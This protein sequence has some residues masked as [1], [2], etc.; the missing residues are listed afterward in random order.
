MP[1]NL[2]HGFFEIVVHLIYALRFLVFG[3][4][5]D[6]TLFHGG[7]PDVNPVIRIVGNTLRND[8]LRAL[9]R[10]LRGGH[11]LILLRIAACHIC[12][13]GLQQRRL[14]VLGQDIVRQR[15]QP[16]RLRHA[17][18]GL[19][20]G[21]V[22]PVQIFHHYQRLG[23]QYLLLQLFRQFTL[24]LDASQ[25]LFL[26]LLQIA[27]ICEALMQIPQLL[28]V[29]RT[30]RFLSVSGNK[31][32]GAAFVDKLYSRFHLPLFHLQFFFHRLKNV[33]CKPCLSSRKSFPLLPTARYDYTGKRRKLQREVSVCLSR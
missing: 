6:H 2:L 25:H 18:A 33:H 22:R 5:G 28:V 9:Q 32:D 17:G 1:R 7:L 12:G 26:L 14:G 21:T 23:R 27:Q 30:R 3:R 13:G 29:Q 24:F 11:L 10:L 20:L 4:A 19:S 16:L 31:G 8:I 15:L